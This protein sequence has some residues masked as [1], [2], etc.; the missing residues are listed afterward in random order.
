[1]AH[2]ADLHRTMQEYMIYAHKC[3]EISDIM[4]KRLAT[5]TFSIARTSRLLYINLKKKLEVLSMFYTFSF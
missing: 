5:P 1:M 2:S 4:D 3:H